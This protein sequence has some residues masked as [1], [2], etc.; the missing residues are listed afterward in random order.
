MESCSL[1]LW[2][3]VG[4]ASFHGTGTKANDYN[5]SAVLDRQLGH[6]GRALGNACPGVFQKYLTG[7]PKGAAAAWMFNGILQ[8]LE[9][10]I[11]PGNRNAD[12]IDKQLRKFENVFYPSRSIATDGIKAGLLKSFGFGQAGGEVLVIHPDYLFA[13][14]DEKEYQSYAEKRARR[15]M[16]SYQYFH[17]MLTGMSFIFQWPF[18]ERSR[19]IISSLI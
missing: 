13:A 7:H 1:P 11:I 16:A 6:L 8:V 2:L 17:E 4:V 14:I 5:E 10:G 19:L 3:C 9:T 18:F 12:N 15:E